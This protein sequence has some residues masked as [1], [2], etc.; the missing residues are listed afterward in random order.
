MAGSFR[1]TQ[2]PG[3]YTIEVT[4]TRRGELLGSARTRFIV[5]QQDLELDNA[6]AD[7]DSMKGVAKASGGEVIEPERLPKWLAELMKKTDYLDVKQET[8]KTLWD[9]WPLFITVVLL[10][11]AEWFLRKRW[12]LV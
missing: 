5:S 2:L 1:E 4:A 8:K 11:T 7:L 12:G 3:D 6:S 10:L 9:Q